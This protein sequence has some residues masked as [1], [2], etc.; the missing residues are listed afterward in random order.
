MALGWL[1]RRAWFPVEAV[2]AAAV[3]VHL[4]TSTCILPVRRGTWRH[5]E[6][7]GDGRALC[8]A[9]VGLGDIDLH[10]AW[11]A[12]HSRH[13]PPL[14]VSGV[15]LGDIDL[16]FAWQGWHLWYWAGSGGAS[17]RGQDGLRRLLGHIAHGAKTGRCHSP[18]LMVLVLVCRFWLH[19]VTHHLSRTLVHT[20]FYTR[21]VLTPHLY[22]QI[23]PTQLFHTHFFDT[24][25]PTQCLHTQRFYIHSCPIPLFHPQHFHTRLSP[26]HHFYTPRLYTHFFHQQHFYK[27]L[28][29]APPFD[30]HFL[31]TPILHHLFSLSCLSH[32]VFT[33]L[34]RLIG[35]S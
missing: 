3:C 5:L 16:H 19:N 8:V 24:H 26:T 17:L 28:F 29:H 10:F 18:L 2:V 25:L 6:N 35:R 1:W 11:Q 34:L 31:H 22:T 4:A 21:Y 15:A 7:L 14:C 23:C 20:T 33:F 13:R 12:L 32:P 27:E 30:I 9:G